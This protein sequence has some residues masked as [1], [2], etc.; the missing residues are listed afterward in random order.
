MRKDSQGISW[1]EIIVILVTVLLIV[2]IVVPSIWQSKAQINERSAVRSVRKIIEAEAN[3]AQAYDTGYSEALSI[4]GP[5]PDAKPSSA[6]AGYVD[7]ELSSGTKEGYKFIYVAGPRD[8]NGR[9]MTY[10][11]TVNPVDPGKSGG[12][13]YFVDQT[14]MIH[15]NK[16]QPATAS[17]PPIGG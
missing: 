6:L 9:I 10:T 11:L 13:F 16:T 3:Y 4:L 2:G 17:D 7:S 5:P 14:G 12:A 15:Q 1:V 8:A